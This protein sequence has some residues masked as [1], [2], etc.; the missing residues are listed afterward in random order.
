MIDPYRIMN[1][2]AA[3]KAWREQGRLSTWEFMEGARI[4][5]AKTPSEWEALTG[6]KRKYKGKSSSATRRWAI[7]LIII[8]LFS[9]FMAFTVPGRAL[10]KKLY[11]VVTTFVGNMLYVAT[12]SETDLITQAPQKETVDECKRVSSLQD[13]FSQIKEPILC[14]NSEKYRIDSITLVKK[15][16]T[17]RLMITEYTLDDIRI[18]VMQKWP[19]EGTPL[20]LNLLLENG[21]YHEYVN[22]INLHF[23]GSY[24]ENDHAYFGGTINDPSTGYV[25]IENVSDVGSIES[26]LSDIAYY[27]P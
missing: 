24:T 16:A 7:A 3:Q 13:A 4:K 21:Q 22:Q 8:I 17:G 18:H 14:L 23:Y 10:A 5:A 11:E 12:V 26:I 19:T 27:S 6:I 2:R 1:Y 9:S 15:R 25:S 20:E